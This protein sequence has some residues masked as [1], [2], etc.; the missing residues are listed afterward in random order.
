LRLRRS[1]DPEMFGTILIANRGEIALRVA[2][3]CREI[4]VRVVAVCST[5]DRDSAVTRVAD[6]TV[7]IGPASAT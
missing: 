4:G 1:S 2:R 3:T 5:A 6:E 7:Q